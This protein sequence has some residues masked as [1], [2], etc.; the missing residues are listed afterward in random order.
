MQFLIR[1]KVEKLRAL[2]EDANPVL[3]LFKFKNRE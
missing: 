2:P 1:R 3:L